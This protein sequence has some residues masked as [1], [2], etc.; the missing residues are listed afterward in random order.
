MV[1]KKINSKLHPDPHLA[2]RE[3]RGQGPAATVARRCSSRQLRQIRATGNVSKNNAELMQVSW[4]L[5]RQHSVVLVIASGSSTGLL[6]CRRPFQQRAMPFHS[7]NPQNT[8]QACPAPH[9]LGAAGSGTLCPNQ[10]NTH[11]ETRTERGKQESSSCVLA[12]RLCP[13]YTS[14]SSTWKCSFHRS[15]RVSCLQTHTAG[16]GA[17]HAAVSSFCQGPLSTP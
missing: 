16:Q 9:S 12:E 8:W 14:E 2:G 15:Y 5:E 11:V 3:G 7:A 10:D 13:C 6:G 4:E 17:P 1:L